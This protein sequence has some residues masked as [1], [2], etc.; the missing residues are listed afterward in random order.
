MSGIGK[1]SEYPGGEGRR[2]IDH[3]L[4]DHGMDRDHPIQRAA[5]AAEHTGRAIYS[6]LQG[7]F[8]RAGAELDR[9]GQNFGDVSKYPD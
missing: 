7:N 1:D 9:A 8:D 4:R 6:A 2:K 3:W 5:H